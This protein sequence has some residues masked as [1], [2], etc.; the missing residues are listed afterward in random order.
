LLCMRTT[1][2][3]ALHI[4]DLRRKLMTRKR[5]FYHGLVKIGVLQLQRYMH[6]MR[7]SALI[8]KN[9]NLVARHRPSIFRFIRKTVSKVTIGLIRLLSSAVQN[10]KLQT[11]NARNRH[12]KL[13]GNSGLRLA[14]EAR[15]NNIRVLANLNLTSLLSLRNRNGWTK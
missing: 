11:M 10:A 15:R 3:V 1:V 6:R 9:V 5:I 4:N 14:S 8:T 12:C 7:L 13:F 2:F